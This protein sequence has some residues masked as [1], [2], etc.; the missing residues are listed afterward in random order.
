MQLN[1]IIT[2]FAAFIRGFSKV[3]Q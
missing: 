3:K 1:Y 2:I